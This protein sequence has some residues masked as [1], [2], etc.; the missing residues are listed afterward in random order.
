MDQPANWLLQL[1]RGQLRPSITRNKFKLGGIAVDDGR[2]CTPA[3]RYRGQ[4][5][6]PF[7]R[8]LIHESSET[9]TKSYHV[10]KK[11]LSIDSSSAI[12]LLVSRLPMDR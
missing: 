6:L 4:S 3:Y 8:P 12:S 5:F 9:I 7:T 10:F 1:K 11:E 2:A